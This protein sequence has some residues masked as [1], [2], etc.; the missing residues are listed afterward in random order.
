MPSFWD[1]IERALRAVFETITNPEDPPDLDDY[2]T[3]PD[4]DEESE[5]PAIQRGENE[6]IL[7]RISD[8]FDVSEP[9]RGDEGAQD[10]GYYSGD[11][12]IYY[13]GDGPYPAEWGDAE[14][15]FWDTVV[16]GKPFQDY[17]NY[18]RAMEAFQHGF[19]DAKEMWDMDQRNEYR[20]DFLE[21]MYMADF[22][23]EAFR[24][25]WGY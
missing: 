11:P 20:D 5:G 23:W 16:N 18:D 19:L 21:E 7:D 15:D 17:D 1:E 13:S 8:W 25:Y 12:F 4:E 9:E 24:D 10:E 22:D 6:G 2:F 3:V 14:I